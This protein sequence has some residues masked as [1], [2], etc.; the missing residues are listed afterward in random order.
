MVMDATLRRVAGR[1]SALRHDPAARAS[2]GDATWRC[3]RDWIGT[4]LRALAEGGALPAARPDGPV[5]ESLARI[6]RQVELLEGA[7]RRSR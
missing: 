6:A 7:L 1:L 2:L 4:A 5:P 3:W